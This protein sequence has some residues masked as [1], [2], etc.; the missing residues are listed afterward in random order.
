MVE[1]REGGEERKEERE[2]GRGIYIRYL[3][4]LS[5]YVYCIPRMYSMSYR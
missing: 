5:V 2:E 3:D 4:I 1:E